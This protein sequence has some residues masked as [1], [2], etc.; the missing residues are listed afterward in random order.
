MNLPLC[1]HAPLGETQASAHRMTNRRH[2]KLS[3]MCGPYLL[4][5]FL[6]IALPGGG[7]NRG[8]PCL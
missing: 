5:H 3:W 2:A 6:F 7:E 4:D 8:G 1:S